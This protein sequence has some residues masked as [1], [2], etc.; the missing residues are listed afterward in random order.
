VGSTPIFRT[1]E[2]MRKK[3][4]KQR[5]VKPNITTLSINARKFVEEHTLIGQELKKERKLEELVKNP[6]RFRKEGSYISR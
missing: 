2:N 6:R 5:K 1:K 3:K 4:R